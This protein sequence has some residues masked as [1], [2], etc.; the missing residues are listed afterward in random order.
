MPRPPV[1]CLTAFFWVLSATVDSYYFFFSFECRTLG[2]PQ[3]VEFAVSFVYNKEKVLMYNSTENKVVFYSE[4][5]AKWAK[6]LKNK[7]HLIRMEVEKALSKCRMFR[8]KM[9]VVDKAV[10]PRVMLRSLRPASGDQPAV[11]MCSAYDFY[12]KP[13]TLTWLRDGEKVTTDVV[14]T[15]ELTDGDWHYQI[16]SQ[17]EF[18]PEPAENISCMVEHLSFREPALFHWSHSDKPSLSESD[19]DRIAVGTAALLLGGV[20][21]LTGLVYYKRKLTGWTSVQ[22]LEL[23]SRTQ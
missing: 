11:L 8:R 18:T 17:L 5:G 13:I 22:V 1:L 4:H 20:T 2:S 21:A 14:S 16:H 10:R 19:R 12:P 6:E 7:T 15:E 9:S 23:G 3:D